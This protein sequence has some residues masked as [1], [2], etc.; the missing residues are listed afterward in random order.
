MNKPAKFQTMFNSRLVILF[1]LFTPFFALGQEGYR[2][3]M[4]Q[5]R[6]YLNVDEG[7]HQLENGEVISDSANITLVDNSWLSLLDSEGRFLT[8]NQIGKYD[9]SKVNLTSQ[10]DS[11]KVSFDIWTEFYENIYNNS[12]EPPKHHVG[13]FEIYLPSSSEVFGHQLFLKWSTSGSSNFEVELLDEFENVFAVY[14]TDKTSYNIDL[15]SKEMA[16]K[17]QVFVRVKDLQNNRQTGMYAVAKLS[18]PDFDNATSL[19]RKLPKDADEISILTEAVLFEQNGWFS[20]VHSL[21][22]PKAKESALLRTFYMA[23]LERNKFYGL[24][25]EVRR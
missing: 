5:G 14:N 22:Y 2:V 6:N 3:I 17:R 9:L 11:S 10:G 23:F 13:V 21:L 20:N 24:I 12:V 7:F 8:L 4:T 16:W 19:M 15:L 18:P 1:F 25:N